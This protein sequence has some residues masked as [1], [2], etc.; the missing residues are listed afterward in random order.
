VEWVHKG[1]DGL[2]TEVC[3]YIPATLMQIFDVETRGNPVGA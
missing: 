3:V 1:K 2:H